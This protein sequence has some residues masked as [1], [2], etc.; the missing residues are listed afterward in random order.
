MKLL[1]I[2]AGVIAVIAS[3]AVSVRLWQENAA[4]K[5]T[6]A[7]MNQQMHTSQNSMA[8]VPAKAHSAKKSTLLNTIQ[9]AGI[10][11][12]ESEVA[13]N[14]QTDVDCNEAFQSE[15]LNEKIQALHIDAAVQQKYRILL[16]QVDS[17]NQEDVLNLLEERERILNMVSH[18]YFTKPI[19]SEFYLEQRDARLAEID[20]SLEDLIPVDKV[21][22]YDLLKDSGFEQ[23]QL[24]T[25]DGELPAKHFLNEF[26]VENLLIAKL[27][28]KATFKKNVQS[29]SGLIDSG[30]KQAGFDELKSAVEN[31]KEGYLAEARSLLDDVQY[32]R[33]RQFDEE[34][35]YE[36]LSSLTAPYQD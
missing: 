29:A 34:S 11:K 33:L 23:F 20:E 19:D 30:S 14:L 21:E 5:E 10:N 32:Q 15:G 36:I 35:F 28:Y 7:L 9:S 22:E 4:L 1:T 26:Q 3:S 18:G 8:S 2:S 31:Y 24:Q 13:E 12:P 25:F 17:Q 16:N 27:R 6:L